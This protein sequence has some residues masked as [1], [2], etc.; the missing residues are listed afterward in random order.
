MIRRVVDNSEIKHHVVFNIAYTV[1]YIRNVACRSVIA[2]VNREYTGIYRVMTAAFDNIVI[3]DANSRNGF[4]MGSAHMRAY[5]YAVRTV[6]CEYVSS[7]IDIARFAQ[8][9]CA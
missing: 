7:D 4:L 1:V 5:K 6:V 9:I 2:Y 3:A 8:I